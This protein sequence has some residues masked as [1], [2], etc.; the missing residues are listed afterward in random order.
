L[1]SGH[2]FPASTESI[3]TYSLALD[4]TLSLARRGPFRRHREE[5]VS[6]GLKL[7]DIAGQA[8]HFSSVGSLEREA[9]LDALQGSSGII[10]LYD[11]VREMEE[12]NTFDFIFGILAQLMQRASFE[13]SA[14]TGRLP[15]YVAVCITKFDDPRVFATARSTGLLSESAEGGLSFPCVH[16][17][18]ARLFFQRLGDFSASGNGEMIIRMLEDYLRPDRVRYFVTS[19][20]GFYLEPR[21]GSFDTD[22]LQNLITE[23]GDPRA[24]RIRGPIRPINVVEPLLWMCSAILNR[25]IARGSPIERR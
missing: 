12:G 22:D 16:N 10:L 3:E 20:I 1:A 18:D 7:V 6:I 13:T 19:A 24:S 17:E 8:T 23:T 9:L 5:H 2:R 14:S 21:S 25:P 15:Q 11:P 4:T